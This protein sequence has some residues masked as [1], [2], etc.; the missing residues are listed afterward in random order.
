MRRLVRRQR[1]PTLRARD[2]PVASARSSQAACPGHDCC[3]RPTPHNAGIEDLR[4][5]REEVNRQILRAEEEKAKIQ[6]V[7]PARACTAARAPRN[8]TA[9]VCVMASRRSRLPRHGRLPCRRLGLAATVYPHGPPQQD[10]R[11]ARPQGQRPQRVR[12]HDPGDRGRVHEDLG[13]VAD[14]ADSAQARG[15]QPVQEAPVLLH[16]SAWPCLS[17]G[18]DARR[19]PGAPRR[20]P[21]CAGGRGSGKPG[22]AVGAAP[23]PA[24][25][26]PAAACSC[27][28][29]ASCPPFVCASFGARF[30]VL[31]CCRRHG[32]PPRPPPHGLPR[33]TVTQRAYGSHCGSRQRHPGADERPRSARLVAEW[34]QRS[35][36]PPFAAPPHP[37]ATSDGVRSVPPSA[38]SRRDARRAAPEPTTAGGRGATPG[39]PAG[40][41]ALPRA[42]GLR[43]RRLQAAAC[44]GQARAA[45]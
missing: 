14:A 37:P 18:K 11:G 32:R 44:R 25:L 39:A 10:Q 33:S 8:S 43:A 45:A 41:W 7:R 9:C 6:K 42:G 1:R 15:H 5:K 26:G 31:L 16:L 22:P 40:R 35:L 17:A 2:S 23:C 27:P 4:E 38:C 34:Q 24:G 20:R 36:P 3:S 21:A 19:R 13:V 30:K 28:A 12:H 29:A